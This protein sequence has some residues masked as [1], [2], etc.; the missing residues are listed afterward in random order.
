[1][2][3]PFLVLKRDT[4]QMAYMKLESIDAFFENQAKWPGEK[5]SRPCLTVCLKN[6]V[7]WHFDITAEE[8]RQMLVSAGA[9]QVNF[10]PGPVR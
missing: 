3:T 9:G 5:E 10:Y 7:N 6:N 2:L 4:G 8:F 1:M